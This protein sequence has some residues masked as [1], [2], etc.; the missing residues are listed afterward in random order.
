[1]TFKREKKKI[2]AWQAL[3]AAHHLHKSSVEFTLPVPS[4]YAGI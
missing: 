2:E 3:Q 1:M 4:A